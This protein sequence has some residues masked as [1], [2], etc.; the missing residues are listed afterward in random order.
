MFYILS[1]LEYKVLKNYRNHCKYIIAFFC[2]CTT[3]PL[4]TN[5][6][7]NSRLVCKERPY[8]YLLIVKVKI[9]LSIDFL[10]IYVYSNLVVSCHVN[11]MIHIF[12]N[13]YC[14]FSHYLP[15]IFLIFNIILGKVTD[16]DQ[17][18]F[19]FVVFIFKV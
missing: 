13:I 14:K 7:R 8:M 1:L 19:C 5:H 12:S 3:Y 10:K 15:E 9:E 16:I 18:M 4:F 17:F 6:A 2:N 11:I